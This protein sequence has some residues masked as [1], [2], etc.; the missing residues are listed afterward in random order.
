[1]NG[2]KSSKLAEKHGSKNPSPVRMMNW[3]SHPANAQASSLN[4]ENLERRK[5]KR[6]HTRFLGKLAAVFSGNQQSL[7]EVGFYSKI[8]KPGSHL[9]RTVYPGKPFWNYEGKIETAP[10]G[11]GLQFPTQQI[12]PVG[13]T[14]LRPL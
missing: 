3:A 8:Q 7:G 2:S 11:Q 10:D 9:P 1:M 4:P 5:S 14:N 6:S 12:G 13:N